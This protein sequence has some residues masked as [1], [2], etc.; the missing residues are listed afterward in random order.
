MFPLQLVVA[1]ALA[2][3]GEPQAEVLDFTA[4][5]CPPCQQVS[6]IVSRLQREGLPIR[7]VDLDENRDLAN[8]FRVKTIPVF[9]LVVDGNEV[10][11]SGR[12]D[13]V[14][15]EAELRRL[16]QM[17]PKLSGTPPADAAP[18]PRTQGGAALGDSAP[19]PNADPRDKK[20]EK[21][22]KPGM[23]DRLLGKKPSA[24]RPPESPT[25]LRGQDADSDLGAPDRQVND[26]L[27]ATV[28]IRIKDAQGENFGTGTIIDSRP[29]R[30]LILTCG[31]IFRGWTKASLIQVDLFRGE[32]VSTIIGTRLAHDLDQDVGLISIS[33]DRP[34]PCC[35]VAP[36]GTNVMKGA[37]VVS[38]GCS[39]GDRP[40]VQRQKVTALN[41]YRGGDNIECSVVPVQGRSGG[42]L[43]D[44]RGRVIGLCM[45][46]DTEHK[47]GLYAGLQRIY[48]L[49]QGCQL[50]HLY[51]QRSNADQGAS[52]ALATRGKTPPAA[53]RPSATLEDVQDADTESAE[54]DATTFGTGIASGPRVAPSDVIGSEIV[55]IIPSNDKT[56]APSK[57]LRL[58]RAS[59]GFWEHLSP[60]LE[61]HATILET[62]MQSAPRAKPQADSAMRRANRPANPAASGSDARSTAPRSEPPTPQKYQRRRKTPASPGDSKSRAAQTA[63]RETPEA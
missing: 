10:A 42:G 31:H 33:T 49:L 25:N 44:T 16:C 46:A 56:G 48:G 59:R 14:T 43:F 45:C 50:T 18:A 36:P 4:T 47:E 8:R 41:R 22:E 30:T 39:R 60:E 61:N 26:P 28:R 54:S 20:V 5:W 17:I 55:I 24:P 62:S 53:E 57:V 12:L 32:K 63:P 40:T 51:D 23:L 19:F 11:R 34:L 3:S 35:P 37:P 1:T 52:N 38:V 6:P 15:P 21:V 2:W 58:H 27:S 9:I 29:G 13:Q 7:K